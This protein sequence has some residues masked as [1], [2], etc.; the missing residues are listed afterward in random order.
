[1]TWQQ[2]S[3]TLD[4]LQDAMARC[5]R[6]GLA[7]FR[8]ATHPGFKAAKGKRVTY[9]GRGPYEPRPLLAAA[10]ALACPDQPALG[11]KA[12]SGDSARQTLIRHYGFMLEGEQAE[13]V[14]APEA[15]PHEAPGVTIDGIRYRLGDLSEQARAQLTH[16]RV[17][18]DRIN[19]LKR[20]L[21]IAR[22]ARQ[23]YAEAL[24]A[25]LPKEVH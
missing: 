13:E 24:A 15:T 3:I 25:A 19:N 1:M 2:A 20:R 12:F 17:T 7:A 6:L 21:A 5:D 11:P 23:A 14:P 16:L 9:Q 4:H 8:S 22:T 10:Y 18:D